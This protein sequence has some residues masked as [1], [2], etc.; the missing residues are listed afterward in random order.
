MFY[1]PVGARVFARWLN[2][3]Y[4]R[5]FVNSA[6]ASSVS[7]LYDDG[8]LKNGT[9]TYSKSDSTALILDV[10]P[11]KTDLVPK[12]RVIARWSDDFSYLP[13]VIEN[14]VQ[15]LNTSYHVKFDDGYERDET[16]YHMRILPA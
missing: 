4:Y 8:I 15:G 14:V 6:N 16:F 7:I 3:G 2:N 10:L 11:S 5:A 13:G 12:Q 1:K 9:V